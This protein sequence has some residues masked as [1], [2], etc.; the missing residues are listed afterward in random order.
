METS[1]GSM[2]YFAPGGSLAGPV[3]MPVLQNTCKE[4]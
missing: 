4:T 1:Y 2:Y 3:N